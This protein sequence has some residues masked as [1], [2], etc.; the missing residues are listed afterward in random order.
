MTRKI[1]DIFVDGGLT[2][3]VIGENESGIISQLVTEPIV[4]EPAKEPEKAV[5]EKPATRGRKKS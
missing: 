4:T 1:G 2:Y 5:E 3:K